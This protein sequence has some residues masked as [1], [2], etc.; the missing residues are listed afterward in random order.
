M[1]FLLEGAEVVVEASDWLSDADDGLL[2][3]LVNRTKRLKPIISR[4]SI[5]LSR[6][7]D[8]RLR[9][10]DFGLNFNACIIY[11]VNEKYAWSE[12]THPSS[13]SPAAAYSACPCYLTGRSR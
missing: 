10:S 11:K 4:K 1:F 7:S 3:Q 8:F 12:P 9:T 2:P 5:V 6:K 13:I